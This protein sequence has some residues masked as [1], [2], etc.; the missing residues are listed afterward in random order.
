MPA[1]LPFISLIA[2]GVG[3][4]TSLYEG[5]KTRDAA[6]DQSKQQAQ[7]ALE[8]RNQAQQQES[9]QNQQLK[10]RAGGQAQAQSGGNLA[11]PQMDA[12]RDLIAGVP[13]NS[14]GIPSTISGG[15]AT[16]GLTN[17]GPGGGL[18]PAIQSLFDGNEQ[19]AM[20]MTEPYPMG[21]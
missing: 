2:A 20:Q 8:Q 5:S 4:G 13:S 18:S 1:I 12:L 3:A 9:L 17:E 21:A 14:S 19:Q 7:L 15:S 10:M 16:P 6:S 11:D